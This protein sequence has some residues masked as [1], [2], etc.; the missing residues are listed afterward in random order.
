MQHKILLPL[1]LVAFLFFQHKVYAQ[2]GFV[3]TEE[4]KIERKFIDGVQEFVLGHYDKAIEIFEKLWVKN[5]NKAPI[6][7]QLSRAY[8]ATKQYGKAIEFGQKALNLDS[9]NEFYAMQLAESFEGNQELNK[10]AEIYLEFAKNAPDDRFFLE[11]AINLHLK[12]GNYQKAIDVLDELEKMVGIEEPISR[13]KFEI[14]SKTDQSNKA[15]EELQSLAN[16]YP[17]KPVYLINLASYYLQLND[18]DNTEKVY[19]LILTK[20]PKN[21]TALK[22]KNISKQSS[23]KENQYIKALQAEIQNKNISLDNKIRKLIPILN[24]LIKNPDVQTAESMQNICEELKNQYP[25]EAKSHAILADIYMLNNDYESAANTYKKTIE[26]DGTVFDVWAQYMESLHLTQNYDDLIKT[27]ENAL[28]RFPN[29]ALIYFYAGLGHNKKESYKDASDIIR[30]GIMMTGRN[31]VLKRNMIIQRIYSL[32]FD[33][34]TDK[35]SE[36]L[37]SVKIDNSLDA[38]ALVALYTIYQKLGN[39]NTANK[40][41]IQAKKRYSN[42]PSIL[43]IFKEK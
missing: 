38:D 18:F 19:D 16:A 40:M 14:F 7:F 33:D 28:Y 9:K 24:D 42:H 31:Q 36:L 3:T 37:K 2:R 5:K 12:D 10:A 32:L 34:Q 29:Q 43:T 22:F 26:L 20:F 35:A 23:N 15:V 4:L 6:A 21:E 11:K 41:K 17:E 1:L 13:Q 30:E 8:E 25:N 27:V 39:S